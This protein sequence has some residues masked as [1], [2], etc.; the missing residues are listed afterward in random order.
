MKPEE[1]DYA[2][3]CGNCKR[4]LSEHPIGENGRLEYGG[5]CPFFYVNFDYPSKSRARQVRRD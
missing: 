3:Y 1:F 2:K 4:P 5:H